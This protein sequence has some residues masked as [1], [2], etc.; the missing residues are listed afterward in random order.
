MPADRAKVARLIRMLTL[1]QGRHGPAG[2]TQP[3]LADELGVETRTVRKYADEL[4]DAGIPLRMTDRRYHIDRTFFLPPIDFTADEAM[5]L[6]LLAESFGPDSPAPEH[7]AVERVAQKIRAGLPAGLRTEIDACL[8]QITV[9]PAATGRSTDP[10]LWALVNAAIAEGTALEVHYTAAGRPRATRVD[11]APE[12]FRFD[13]Y[14]LYFGQR[15]W[16]AVGAHHGRNGE[17]RNLKLGRFN[18]AVP[19]SATFIVPADF[20]LD[21]HRGHAWRFVRGD[22]VRRRIVLLFDADR[23]DTVEETLWHFTQ[24]TERLPDGRLRVI[25]DIDGLSEIDA[26]ILGYGVHIVVEEPVELRNRVAAELA[27]ALDRYASAESTDGPP[28]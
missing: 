10:E 2:W 8:P 20:T 12:V 23:A 5:S 18:A 19:T 13:P 3:A 1:V 7:R 15:S 17:L 21:R 16:F 27:R 26:W 9:H 25:F 28:V 24:S 14:A 4:R 11:A 22:A 6:L